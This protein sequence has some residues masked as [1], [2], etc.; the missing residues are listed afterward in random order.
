MPNFDGTGPQGMGP[1]TGWGMG[2]CGQ[3]QARGRGLNRGRGFGRSVNG[4]M[5]DILQDIQ[6]R[7]DRLESKK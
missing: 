5:M 7:L 3:G 6:D 1:Q 2:P 4:G